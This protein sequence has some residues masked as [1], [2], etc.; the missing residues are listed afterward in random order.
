VEYEMNTAAAPENAIAARRNERFSAGLI[1]SGRT[2]ETV[3]RTYK[4]LEKLAKDQSST[5]SEKVIKT[6]IERRLL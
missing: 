2:T 5:K 6:G 1:V 4:F 3:I